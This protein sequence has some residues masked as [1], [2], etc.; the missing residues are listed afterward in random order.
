MG[1]SGT[2]SSFLWRSLSKKK[3]TS[4]M[5]NSS[6][7]Y[8]S[9]LESSPRQMSVVSNYSAQVFMVL[10]RKILVKH[11]STSELAKDSSKTKRVFYSINI[12]GDQF[13]CKK[14]C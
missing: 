6:K 2:Q 8:T 3:D 7:G 9:L 10:L 1:L 12:D 4:D 5:V 14:Y 13:V 11:D